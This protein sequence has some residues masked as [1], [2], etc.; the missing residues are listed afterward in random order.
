MSNSNAPKINET[1]KPNED[2]DFNVEDL[3]Q[4]DEEDEDNRGGI[5][6][7]RHCDTRQNC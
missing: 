5:R 4:G 1:E 7:S 3:P 2:P 6:P